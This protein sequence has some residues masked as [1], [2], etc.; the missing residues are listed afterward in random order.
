[1]AERSYPQR[2]YSRPA[3]AVEIMLVRHGASQAAVEG[4]PFE[5]LEGQAD[6][7]LSPEGLAQA[8]AVA[9][10][11]ADKSME[12]LFITPLCRTAQTA[13]A[14]AE[15][16]GLEPVVI[17]EL[18]EVH[19]GELDG[20]AFRIALHAGD[21]V[22][23][24]VFAQERWDVIPGAEPMEDLAERARAGIERI[25][26]S[27]PAGATVAAI[28]H[29]GII[30]ELCHQATA[31]KRF[32]FTHADN[33]SITRLIVFPDGRWWLRSFNEGGHLG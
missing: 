25:V 10:F 4:Q 19:L 20:G 28:V 8:K 5:L 11:L 24:E 17:A 30:G 2:D 12:A 9:T 3:E 29:G 6:P 27:V 26:A 13:Q 22:V 14:I 7:P 23:Q 32:A 33:C 21:P 18:R 31:S 15:A 16:T 1:M